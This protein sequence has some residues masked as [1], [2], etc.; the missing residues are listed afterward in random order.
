MVTIQRG[1]YAAVSA[2]S[3]LWPRSFRR[4]LT[5]LS[6]GDPRQDLAAHLPDVPQRLRK[7]VGIAVVEP[8]V[9]AGSG[10]RNQANRMCNHKGNCLGFRFA[11]ALRRP[12]APRGEVKPRVSQFVREHAELLGGRQARNEYDRPR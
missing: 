12:D 1:C 4:K 2:E 3:I 5:G 10:I 6:G 8:Y 9:I 7:C 11:D